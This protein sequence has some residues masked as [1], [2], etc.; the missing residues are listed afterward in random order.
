ME[1]MAALGET[2]DRV[3]NC[4]KVKESTDHNHCAFH[5]KIPV[6][7]FRISVR[8]QKKRVVQTK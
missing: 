3:E 2:V 5:T 6:L 1:V 4:R 7:Y 8:A